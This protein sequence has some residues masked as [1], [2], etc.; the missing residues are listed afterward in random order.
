MIT[1]NKLPAT[2]LPKSMH[3]P[4]EGT[5]V[6]AIGRPD[7]RPRIL[8]GASNLE[9]NPEPQSLEEQLLERWERSVLQR[10]NSR[11]QV[12]RPLAQQWFMLLRLQGRLE[13]R[14]ITAFG[15]GICRAPWDL[16]EEERDGENQE[17]CRRG[18]NE[19][20]E[21][22]DL[23]IIRLEAIPSTH[24]PVPHGG[25][26]RWSEPIAVEDLWQVLGLAAGSNSAAQKQHEVMLKLHFVCKD[27]VRVPACPALLAAA[28]PE[29][30]A[31]IGFHMGRA[32]SDP[33]IGALA[34]PMPDLSSTGL[35][36]ILLLLD[37]WGRRCTDV[38]PA[39]YC[40]SPELGFEVF[41][42]TSLFLEAEKL[43]NTILAY[44][45]YH[46]PCG[47]A[48]VDYYDRVEAY[49]FKKSETRERLIAYFLKYLREQML[50]DP[51]WGNLFSKHFLER[52]NWNSFKEIRIRP[53][54][55]S[56]GT[57]T[58]ALMMSA[59][60]V[61]FEE[62]R[63]M[64]LSCSRAYWLLWDILVWAAWRVS[65]QAVRM[66]EAYLP[67]V[68]V[69]RAAYHCSDR[70]PVCGASDAVLCFGAAQRMLIRDFLAPM[71]RDLVLLV[72]S[73]SI[74]T[75]LDQCEWTW[76]WGT[77]ESIHPEILVF[78]IRPLAVI[79]ASRMRR[80]LSWQALPIDRQH[81]IRRPELPVPHAPSGTWQQRA[82]P[83]AWPA[84]SSKPTRAESQFTIYLHD[85]LHRSHPGI[86]ISP[87]AMAQLGCFIQAI[88]EA[89]AQEAGRIARANT[90]RALFANTVSQSTICGETIERAVRLL[91]PLQLAKHTVAH[92]A[93]AYDE[94]S[95]LG[96]NGDSNEDYDDDDDDDNFLDDGDAEGN[97]G[98]SMDLDP[99]PE[100]DEERSAFYIHPL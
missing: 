45:L 46:M 49:D 43:E 40:L 7:D 16:E 27:E 41:S 33:S 57:V 10:L 96:H 74:N 1:C 56:F 87:D 44:T 59:W 69:Y 3:M 89:L 2:T 35:L 14:A 39:M 81:G 34:I 29:L 4:G 32:N 75:V 25:P 99:P 47:M 84:G 37:N 77:L 9:T 58:P 80:A 82:S 36:F 12:Y 72:A 15:Q 61:A 100:S 53:L 71:P 21:I 51:A 50:K 52:L 63:S 20:L 83:Y 86:T 48:V 62:S 18:S 98:D 8:H 60:S 22:A 30:L 31:L 38:G 91:L 11:L 94:Y 65:N 68:E 76:P 78:K 42:V 93:K 92:G 26:G 17:A 6:V 5:G 28:S 73:G 79:G 95:R 67:T 90:R 97:S 24:Y 19:V 88:L 64:A 13:V 54:E 66:M 70:R 85:L 23:Q 55:Q